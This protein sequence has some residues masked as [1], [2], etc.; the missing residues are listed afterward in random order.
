MKSALLIK[1]GQSTFKILMDFTR[2][3]SGNYKSRTLRQ[4]QK[5]KYGLTAVIDRMVVITEDQVSAEGVRME[6]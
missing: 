6:I 5:T 2:I 4:T 1:D 3:V